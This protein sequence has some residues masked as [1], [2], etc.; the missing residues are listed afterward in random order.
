MQMHRDAGMVK[1][2]MI[3][4]VASLIV[5]V[6]EDEGVEDGNDWLVSEDECGED[7]FVSWQCG[8]VLLISKEQ[9]W[10]LHDDSLNWGVVELS[11]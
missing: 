5:P 11:L 1:N 9:Q 4:T 7:W 10:S 8:I 3:R 6:S 2:I